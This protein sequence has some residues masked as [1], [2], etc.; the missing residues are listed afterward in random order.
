[1]GR[2]TNTVA[3]M[4]NSSMGRGYPTN[5]S[6]IMPMQPVGVQPVAMGRGYPQV[7][8][9]APQQQPY[10]YGQPTNPGVFP[11]SGV[12]YPSQPGLVYPQ[13]PVQPQQNFFGQQN[14]GYRYP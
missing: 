12:V 3:T 6:P 4:Q 2:G 7:V 11:A 13:Q 10:P 1:M 14:Q 9:Y 8:G 5:Q